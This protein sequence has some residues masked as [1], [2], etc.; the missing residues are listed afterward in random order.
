MFSPHLLKS[1]TYLI[2]IR[3]FKRGHYLTQKMRVSRETNTYKPD[4]PNTHAVNS[5]VSYLSEVVICVADICM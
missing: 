3:S 1:I 5:V 2:A 4:M